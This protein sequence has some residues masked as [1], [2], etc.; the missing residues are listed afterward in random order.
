M[1]L[2]QGTSGMQTLNQCL[3]GLYLKR[4]VTLEEAIGSSSDPNE[5]QQIIASGGGAKSGG[6]GGIAGRPPAARG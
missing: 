5:L 2:G 4:Q 3:A 1:Q 6:G